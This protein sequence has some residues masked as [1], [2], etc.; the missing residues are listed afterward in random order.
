MQSGPLRSNHLC[1]IPFASCLRERLDEVDAQFQSMRSRIL[2][3]KLL[4]GLLLQRFTRPNHTMFVSYSIRTL[5]RWRTHQ[6]RTEE[7]FAQYHARRLTVLA[8]C[9]STYTEC[10]SSSSCMPHGAAHMNILHTRYVTVPIVIQMWTTIAMWSWS[11][12]NLLPY[13]R[14]LSQPLTIPEIEISLPACLQRTPRHISLKTS[15]TSTRAM[16][17]L[18]QTCSCLIRDNPARS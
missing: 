18:A 15:F 9:G 3:Y 16:S 11:S 7:T 12:S 5:Q 17:G 10:S 6:H 2:A 8:E 13:L 14:G 1:Q 4:F